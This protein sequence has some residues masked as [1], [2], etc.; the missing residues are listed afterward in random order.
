M[1]SLLGKRS[2]RIFSSLMIWSFIVIPP[3]FSQ[4]FA[5]PQKEN[6]NIFIA[7]TKQFN[8]F[9]ARFNFKSDFKGNPVDSIFRSKMPREKM[10]SLL[11]DL[12]DPR[13]E[14]F[15]NSFSESYAKTKTD[16]I[17]DI[18][19]KNILISNHSPGIIAE[20]RTRILYKGE[21][22]TIR[23][24]LN[25]ELVG[26]GMYKWVLLSAKGD[27]FGIFKM[28]TTMVRFIPPA[29]NETDFINLKR[30]MEDTDFLQ[31]Y[32]FSDFKP[33]FLTLFFY[34]I[35]SG[36]IKFEYVEEV[37]YHIVDI[38]GWYF[39]VKEFNRRDLNSGWLISDLRINSLCLSDFLK[40]F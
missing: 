4:N 31:Y 1:Y 5:D 8:E 24:F 26:K 7:R 20:A 19:S 37:V 16:F 11:F 15:N 23:L 21:P 27:I 9:T 22:Q 3:L 40:S 2:L 33:D 17:N 28:D 38:P 30:A 25:Q 32:A 34:Y 29:S 14:S 12:K 35:R 36:Q 6:E 10:I 39:T 13:A 18:C